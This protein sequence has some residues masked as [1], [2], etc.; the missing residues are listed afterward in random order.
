MQFAALSD[1]A[2]QSADPS[3]RA[4]RM[5]TSLG[6][7][8]ER[9]I[10]VCLLL[11]SLGCSRERPTDVIVDTAPSGS[12]FGPTVPNAGGPP[13]PAPHGMV[14]IPGWRFSMGAAEEAAA[15]TDARPIHRVYV[16]GFWMDRTEVTNGEFGRFVRATGYVTVAERVPTSRGLSR[17]RPRRILSPGRR[18][19]RRRHQPVRSTRTSAGGRTSNGA[20]WRHPRARAVIDRAR[21]PAGRSRRVRRAEAYARWAGKR[22]PTEAELEFAARGGLAG[23]R[24]RVGRRAAA[25]TA[26]GWPT[27]P[28]ALSR[29]D[30]GERRLD[31]HR[32]GRASSRRTA[33]GCTTWPATSGSGV[34]TGIAPTPTRSSS[35]G[36]VARN[37]TGPRASDDPTSRA[38]R[39]GCSEAAHSCARQSTARA[40]WS[41]RGKGEI[42]R[43]PTTSGS[44]AC[45]RPGMP[46]R[47][48]PRAERTGGRASA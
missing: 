30:T 17:A 1:S 42:R 41:A 5:T 15:T 12:L 7:D 33:T 18:C 44:G 39:S 38:H 13:G 26:D 16:D 20:S 47:S 22:L 21:A 40:I 36:G 6:R 11:L 8:A 46:P 28:G 24:Y 25:A 3:S 35:G 32:A 43:A 9:P 23:K 37:P 19:S 29:R 48:T 4:L 27:H 31:R 2:A 45:D 14:W 10:R 34:A